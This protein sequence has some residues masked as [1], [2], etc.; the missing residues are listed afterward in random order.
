M[1]EKIG[2][3]GIAVESLEKAIPFYRDV[4]GLPFEGIEVVEREQVKTAIFRVGD[5]RI[6]LLESTSP[7]GPNGKFL[8]KRGEGIHHICFKVSNIRKAISST[9]DMGARMIDEEPREGIHGSKVGF[10]HPR[11]TFG[12]LI[13]YAEETD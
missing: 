10:L 5:S 3:V 4:L 13:E 1:I 8:E 2:H 6:E 12:V 9:L 7:G 11:S